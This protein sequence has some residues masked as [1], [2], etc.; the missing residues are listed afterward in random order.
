MEKIIFQ[1]AQKHF[2]VDTLQ[3]RNLDRLDF[4]DVSVASIK[5]ALEDAY[6]AGKKEKQKKIQIKN[7][8][9]L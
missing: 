2:N 3:T 7:K 6:Q 1:I 8:L 4:Y 9:G 5:A